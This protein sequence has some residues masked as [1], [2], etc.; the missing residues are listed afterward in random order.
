MASLRDIKRK[1]GSVKNTGQITKAMNLVS[2]V[3]LQKTRAHFEKNKY[4]TR[5]IKEVISSVSE[6]TKGVESVYVNNR[7]A[8]N[9]TAYIILTSDRGLCGSYNQNVFKETLSSKDNSSDS[10]Y[11]VI[12]R[13]GLAFLKRKGF[14]VGESYLGISE[15]PIY[16]DAKAIGKKIMSMY[17]KGEIKEVKLISTAFHS[18][19]NQKV[20]TYQLLPIDISEIKSEET[21]VRAI[22]DFEPSTEAVFNYILPKYIFSVL[23][24]AMIEASVCEEASRMTAMDNA[25]ENAKEIIDKLTLKFNRV[26]QAAITKEISEIVGGANAMK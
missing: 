11:F 19:I 21:N 4:F 1:I 25:T 23:Y 22:M 17:E 6:N 13:K 24:G 14:E 3:K 15:D 26:R 12:G 5:K 20:N 18:I 2:S 7:N 10:I 9:R 16:D 8:E